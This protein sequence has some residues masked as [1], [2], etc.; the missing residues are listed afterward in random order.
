MPS[1][2]L[3]SLAVLALAHGAFASPAVEVNVDLTAGSEPFPHNWKKSFGSGH[4]LLATRA[5][6]QAQLEICVAE[7]GL[8]GVRMHGIFDD[9]MSVTPDG[10]TYFWFNVDTVLDFLV[11]QGVVPIIELSFVPMAIAADKTAWVFGNRGAYKGIR[12]PPADFEQWYDLV[13]AF[14]EHLLGRYGAGVLAE[15]KFEVWNEMWGMPYPSSYLPLYNASARALKDVHPAL[16]VG[17]PASANL[18]NI[19]DLIHDTAAMKIPLDFIS[20]HH[21]PSDPSCSSS[22]P[23]SALPDCYAA[24]VLEAAELAT[25]ASL[26]FLLTEMKD[27]LQGGPGTGFGGKHGDTAYAAAFIFHTIPLLTSLEVVSWWTFSD[28][29]EE[30]WMIGLPFYGGYG[31]QTVHGVRKP[32]FRAFEML[33][34]AGT[35]RITGVTVTDPKPEYLGGSTISVLATVGDSTGVGSKLQ[36]FL[37]N[38]GPEEGA[39]PKPWV[40][41]ARNVS[42]TLQS[43]GTASA[44]P[45]V[46][47]LKRVDDQLTNPR[48]VWEKDGSPGYPTPLQIAAY[49]DASAIIASWVDV[50]VDQAAGTVS[51]ELE[52]PAYGVAVLEL[53]LV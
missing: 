2:T 25:N 24:D 51:L 14:G 31:L 28:I 19:A 34:A 37:S 32:A 47:L 39:S 41:V 46:A 12:G 5:D 16:K 45:T 40:P 7:L 35:T 36:L 27:G 20:T 26:P 23:H 53:D 6:W 8:A 29:F 11:A 48:S 52:L 1:A 44:L 4:T 10:K 30:N 50:T 13:K 15:W 43:S 9:D 38:F 18:A 33:A 42:L 49:H 17:G 22:G 3:L 21:Y